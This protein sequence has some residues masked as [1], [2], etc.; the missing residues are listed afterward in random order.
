MAVGTEVIGGGAGTITNG[1]RGYSA[2]SNRS[3]KAVVRKDVINISADVV[4]LVTLIEQGSQRS[5]VGNPAF[6]H[7]EGDYLPIAVACS[8]GLSAGAT[9]TTLN[10]ATGQGARVRVGD[11]LFYEPTQEMLRVTARSTDALTVTRA[12]GGTAQAVTDGDELKIMG[13]A[14]SD[15]ATA[16]A[17][18]SSEPTFKTNYCQIMRTPFELTGRAMAVELY[19]GG[20]EA[21]VREENLT[22]HI[23]KK[24]LSYLLSNNVASSDPYV[25]GGLLYWISSNL[26]NFGGDLDDTSLENFFIAWL[27]RNQGLQGT[28]LL[29][30]GENFMKGLNRLAKDNIRTSQDEKVYGMEITSYRTFA[31]T[32]KIKQHGMLTP[33]GSGIAAASRGLPGYVFGIQTKHLGERTLRG[34]SR[35]LIP[36]IETPGTDGKKWEYREDVGLWL[37][38]Q[39]TFAHGYGITG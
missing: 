15:G 27:R 1:Q 29:L 39:K 13:S 25:T 2:A 24:E 11:L 12:V 23:Q 18:V 5:E 36:N 16:V 33:M 7:L 6:D 3:V 21:R 28:C 38:S 35:K 20:E 19:G 30:A 9:N 37:A 17:S 10:V 14:H 22:Q 31:G 8:G 32:I 4:P 34:R 26:T